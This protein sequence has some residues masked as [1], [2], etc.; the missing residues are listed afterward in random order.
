MSKEN[1]D[2]TVTALKS[3][4]IRDSHDE[5]PVRPSTRRALVHKDD[6]ARIPT[7]ESPD[8]KPLPK[9]KRK[10]VPTTVDSPPNPEPKRLP[11][12]KNSLPTPP[13]SDH[14]NA[15]QDLTDSP[16]DPHLSPLLSLC[17]DNASSNPSVTPFTTWSASLEPFFTIVKI[18]E[19]SYGEVYRLCLKRSHP[20]FTS[21]DE[22][23]LKILPLKPPPTAKKKSAAQKKRE[24][25]MSG[26][27]S[28]V[29]EVR[30]LRRMSPVPGFTNFRGVVVLKGRPSVGFVDAWRAFNKVRPR[31]EKS[32]F[33]DPSRKG[34]YSDEQLWAVIEM[35]DAGIDLESV[36]LD[37]VWEVWDVFWGVALALAKGEEECGFEHRDLHL[38]NICVRSRR[39]D[40]KVGET[41]IRGVGSGRRIGFTGLETTLIDYTLS[42]AEM[43]DVEGVAFLDLEGLGW[44]FEQ[45]ASV[46]Y[47]Y[48]IY[49]LMRRAACARARGGLDD[50]SDL[51][52]ALEEPTA[53][54][55]GDR[56][57]WREFCPAT[58]VIWLHYVLHKLLKPFD[59]RKDDQDDI[60]ERLGGGGDKKCAEMTAARIDN[61][62]RQLDALLS[63]DSSGLVDTIGSTR[64][65][66]GIAIEEGW[67]DE[68][69]V[70]ENAGSVFSPKK[71]SPRDIAMDSR[72]IK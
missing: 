40:E 3:L 21:A 18:A 22:S 12:P 49:R 51:V 2:V 37:T 19:A 44:L 56:T 25:C 59:Q 69:D 55:N 8:Q 28:V 7:P 42:R 11:P 71:S 41:R 6:N 13:P 36:V 46:E 64:D 67:L 27:A 26:V 58:N 57:L 9:A 61:A 30:L 62:L 54:R 16:K 53:A 66:I 60:A 35:Q 4:E 39:R 17:S 33:P 24:E 10:V 23:V 65:L 72:F 31:G 1:I 14:P 34:S 38:G 63:V 43:S 47:Q 45:D 68:S 5:S 29:S 15:S 70:V 52:E 32:A 20:S 50:F 48:E